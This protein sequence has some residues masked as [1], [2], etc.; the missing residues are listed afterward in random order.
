MQFDFDTVVSRRGSGS[1][2]WD[3]DAQADI[4]PM[5]VADMDFRTAPAVIAALEQRVA[6]GIFG[7]AAMPDAF[8]EAVQG[9]Q[10]RRHGLLLEREWLLYTSGVVPAISA[11]LRAL[12]HPGDRVVVQTPVYNC[13]FSSIRNMGCSIVENPLVNRD[14]RYEM[15]FE[16]L[17]RKVALPD[18]R[19]L[20]L[21]N[22]HN[23]VGRVWSAQELRKLGEICLR[24]G[25][26]VVSDEIHA[27][28]VLP[29]HRHQPFAAL[30]PAFRQRSVTCTAATKAFN[31]AGLQIAT[32]VAADPDLRAGINKALNVHEVCD[33]NP[34]GIAATIAAYDAGEGWLDALRAY[35]R[36]NAEVTHAFVAQRLPALQMT[37]PEA[38]Y[39]AWIDCRSLGRSSAELSAHL[40]EKAKL[41]ISEGT[42]Y[43]AQG[44]GFIRLNMACPRTTLLDGLERLASG[45]G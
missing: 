23:P 40:V 32:I 22:P 33:V 21:C 24:H 11:V 36:A 42:I 28:L 25:V 39:L 3:Q 5:W 29:G 4:L 2:K 1:A 15:D 30:D 19:A 27:D 12:T 41:R 6:H 14:G 7:Y 45:L 34:F 13:F 17:E 8:Y 20:L 26:V 18:V 9:W 10:A 37:M 43:G 44:E 31:F 35:I 38:T 16:D